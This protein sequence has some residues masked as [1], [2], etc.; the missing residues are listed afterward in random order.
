MNA[1]I[2][3]LERWREVG[4]RSKGL[5]ELFHLTSEGSQHLDRRL[6]AC[7]KELAALLPAVTPTTNQG[8]TDE[9]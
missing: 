4:A 6:E 1:L 8:D 3:E 7:V 9:N 5:L 2:A